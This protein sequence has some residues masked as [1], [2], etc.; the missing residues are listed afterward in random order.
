MCYSLKIDT[1]MT[2][3]TFLKPRVCKFCAH[4]PRVAVLYIDKIFS[5]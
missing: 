2:S 4:T 5:I 1:K 3:W